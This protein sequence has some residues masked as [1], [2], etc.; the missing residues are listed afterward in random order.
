MSVVL[1]VIERC[2]DGIRTL[3]FHR[4]VHPQQPWCNPFPSLSLFSPLL[5]LASP[6]FPSL[7]S[8]TLSS[9][10]PCP[11]FSSFLPL[12][13]GPL[14]PAKEPGERYKL[15]QRGLGRSPSRNR[16]WCILAL[17]YDIWW[18]HFQWFSWESIYKVS[19]SLNNIK[20]NRDHGVR[21]VI[22]FKAR[23]SVFTAVNMFKH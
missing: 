2:G 8:P 22:L 20:A 14:N 3:S 15:Q 1:S 23:F 16:I 6:P 21:R 5:F 9:P 4:G 12:E 7:L 11:S 17:K 19:C 18:Q 10:P 13:V